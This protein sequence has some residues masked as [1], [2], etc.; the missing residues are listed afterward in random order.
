MPPLSKTPRL[1]TSKNKICKYFFI[2]ID[3]LK[4]LF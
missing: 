4:I 3:R 1:Y 2:S